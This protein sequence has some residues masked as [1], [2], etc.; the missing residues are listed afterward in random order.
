MPMLYYTIHRVSGSNVAHL[1][2][3]YIYGYT[4]MTM[5]RGEA[6]EKAARGR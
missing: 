6:G 4:I 2:A 3:K 5:T 1:S